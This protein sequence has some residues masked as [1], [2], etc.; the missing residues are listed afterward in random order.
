[1]ADAFSY[2]YIPYRPSQD[3]TVTGAN[4]A[5]SVDP[6]GFSS[7]SVN[8]TTGTMHLS[9]QGQF[10]AA[11]IEI[12]EMATPDYTGT[13]TY[14]FELIGSI[15]VSPVPAPYLDASGYSMQF[16]V[17]AQS[18]N[19]VYTQY[20]TPAA[21]TVDRYLTGVC[22]ATSGESLNLKILA[23]VHTSGTVSSANFADTGIFHIDVPAG[24]SLGY[25]DATFLSDPQPF[26][27]VSVP[28]PAGVMCLATGFVI[29]ALARRRRRWSFFS[30]S[31]DSS[32]QY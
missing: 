9:S 20:A 10:G 15:Q 8:Q 19:S 31:D 4:S 28:E 17:D 2:T 5:T 24:D 30:H 7:A 23:S 21:S 11:S 6:Y 14:T 13:F 27:T 3:N 32:P 26:E 22:S 25:S 29:L 18:C 16:G 1:M 12:D